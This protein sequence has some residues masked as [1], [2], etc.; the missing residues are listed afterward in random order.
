[1]QQRI[2]KQAK[3]VIT[4]KQKKQIKM[5]HNYIKNTSEQPIK[6]G[7]FIPINQAI[8]NNGPAPEKKKRLRRPKTPKLKP[9]VMNNNFISQPITNLQ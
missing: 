3:K 6:D 9:P 1:M 8:I 4:K 2:E 7:V 5:L